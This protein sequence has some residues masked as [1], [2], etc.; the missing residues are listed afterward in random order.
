MF[1]IFP[2]PARHKINIDSTIKIFN[3]KK[4]AI[5]SSFGRKVS[6]GL[7]RNQEINIQNLEKGMYFL[8]IDDTIIKFI[9]I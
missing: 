2:N 1:N 8:K 3:I 4:Y 5:Y 6:S 9:K 7:I